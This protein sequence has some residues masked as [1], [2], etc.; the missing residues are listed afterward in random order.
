MEGEQG[1]SRR[2]DAE[3]GK[4]SGHKE[5]MVRWEWV[6]GRLGFNNWDWAEL[7]WDRMNWKMTS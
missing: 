2:I 6:G 1:G 7:E 4:W 3:M 5:W